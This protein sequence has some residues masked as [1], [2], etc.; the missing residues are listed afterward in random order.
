MGKLI[1]REDTFRCKSIVDGGI[2]ETSTGL[3]QLVLSLRAD[4]IYDFDE[5]CWVP[6]DDVEE[7]EITAFLVLVGKKDNEIFHCKAIEKALGWDGAGFSSLAAIDFL[8]AGIQFTTKENIWEDKVSIQVAGIDHYDAEPG[9]TVNK[10]DAAEV[11]GLDAK[12]ASFFRKRTGEKKPKPVG[13][14]K[15]PG[16]KSTTTLPAAAK[17]ATAAGAI[18]IE[19]PTSLTSVSGRAGDDVPP[20]A[21]PKAPV[22]KP[23]KVKKG[24][25]CTQTEAWVAAKKAKD[26]SISDEKLIE[27][28]LKAVQ[29]LAPDGDEDKMSPELWARVRDVVVGQVSDDIPF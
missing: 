5:K 6:W 7:R 18:K 1:D 25:G 19:E 9:R 21:P 22:K 10:L 15:V 3:P 23:K 13:A 28:W 8:A 2:G 27:V 14:P 12:Y 17:G 20:A 11:K 16:K 4:E 24:T 26:K 29:T